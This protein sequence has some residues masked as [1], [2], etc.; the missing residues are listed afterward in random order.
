MMKYKTIAFQ[1]FII[2]SLFFIFLVVGLFS[3][4]VFLFSYYQNGD[5]VHYRL[6]YEA[7]RD[8]SFISAYFSAFNYIGASDPVSIL[9]IWFGSHAGFDKDVY[10]SFFNS[11]MAISLYFLCR[12]FRSGFLFFFLL[13]MSYYF[14]VL[15]TGAE[16]LKFAYIFLLIAMLLGGG[17]RIV[18]LLLAVL[19]HFQIILLLPSVFLYKFYPNIKKAVFSL[20][21]D[22]IQMFGALSIFMA[23]AFFLLIFWDR[24]FSKYKAYAEG[25]FRF[26]SLLQ[27]FVLLVIAIVVTNNWKRMFVSLSPFFLSVYFLGGER[28][29]MIA[30]TFFIGA[31]LVEN[32]AK[33]P[34]IMLLLVYLLIKSFVFVENIFLYGNGFG[35][36]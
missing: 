31:V 9:I 11:I 10:M 34:F 12:R 35:N 7:I 29:N 15:M 17:G 23:V 16:R 26:E 19:S 25:A 36:S 4:S 14:L 8:Y 6:F 30:A 33:H 13:L 28:V 27:V 1:A 20:K 22:R 32:K 24:I 21:V 18:F 3:A 2:N 5:Q